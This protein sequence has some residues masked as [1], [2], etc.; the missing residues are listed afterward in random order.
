MLSISMRDF[1][2]NFTG[3][4]EQDNILKFNVTNATLAS[5]N[6]TYSSIGDFPISMMVDFLNFGIKSGLPAF[7]YWLYNENQVTIPL[8]LFWMFS[9]TD[10]NLVYHDDYIEAGLTPHFN[11]LFDYKFVPTPLPNMATKWTWMR[12]H[13]DER[14]NYMWNY[15]QHLPSIVYQYA[16]M[17]EPTGLMASMMEKYWASNGMKVINVHYPAGHYSPGA[18]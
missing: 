15:E 7:N 3:I 4:V 13:I 9:L 18:L 10:L 11:P 8:N 16:K 1:F 17:Y 6:T 5:I 2:V 12:E 14:G